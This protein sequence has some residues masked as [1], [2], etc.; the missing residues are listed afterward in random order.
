MDIGCGLALRAQAPNVR[1]VLHRWMNGVLADRGWSA[2]AWA[3]VAGIA[4][5]S[6]TRFLRDPDRASVPG[7]ETIGKL[8]WAAGSEPRL[9]GGTAPDPV[10][11]VP[12]VSVAEARAALSGP[13]ADVRT[14]LEAVRHDGRPRIVVDAGTSR[15]AV[16]LRVTSRHMN[17]A[18]ILPGDN[19]V[20]EPVDARPPRPGDLVLVLDGDHACAYRWH[21]PLLVPASSDPDC[22][23]PIE[24]A[25]AHIIGMVTFVSRAVRA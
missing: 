23:A 4:P 11:H 21:A 6:L 19:V 15:R 8:A 16:A 24:I 2:A 20:V 18:G 7:A 3:R 12:L 14:W 25:G 22:A 1:T 17:A 13:P 9:L 5:T 10:S